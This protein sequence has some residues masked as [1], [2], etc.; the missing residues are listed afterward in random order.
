M[1]PELRA[2]PEDGGAEGGPGG[3]RPGEGGQPGREEGQGGG[4]GDEG[5]GRGGHGAQAGREARAAYI[6]DRVLGGTTKK[7]ISNF[8]VVTKK[9]WYKNVVISRPSP[10]T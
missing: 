4:H 1:A 9:T 3:V 7:M 6:L 8:S 5:R 10:F 2:G